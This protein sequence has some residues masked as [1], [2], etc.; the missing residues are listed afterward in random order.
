MN[1]IIIAFVIIATLF[2][3]CAKEYDDS[4]LWDKQD[5]QDKRLN[6]LENSIKDLKSEIEAAKKDIA[7]NKESITE[8]TTLVQ[9]FEDLSAKVDA[10]DETNKTA[11]KE[12]KE[13]LLETINERLNTLENDSSSSVNTEEIKALKELIKDLQ[14]TTNN[15]GHLFNEIYQKEFVTYC[16]SDSELHEWDTMEKVYNSLMNVSFVTN[17]DFTE[18]NTRLCSFTS[19]HYC[20]FTDSEGKSTSNIVI[21]EDNI[22]QF[23][24]ESNL[25]FYEIKKINEYSYFFKGVTTN[26]QYTQYL[27][28]LKEKKEEF[29]NGYSSYEKLHKVT[30]ITINPST[31]KMNLNESLPLSYSLT[32]STSNTKDIVWTSSDGTICTIEETENNNEI[33]VKAIK[34]GLCDI[35]ATS[36]NRI[37]G[38]CHIGV[39]RIKVSG[40]ELSKKDLD[41]ELNKTFKLN[42]IITPTVASIKD[43]I[44]TSN[45]SDIATVDETGLVTAINIGETVIKAT[46]KDGGFL[47]ECKINVLPIPLQEIS[48]I[49][50]SMDLFEDDIQN[51]ALIF[52][53]ENASNKN[54]VWTIEDETIAVILDNNKIKAL[55][56]GETILTAISEDG[57][58]K[59]SI[60]IKVNDF[61]SF[62]ETNITSSSVVTIMDRI[63]GGVFVSLTN[64]SSH[65]VKIIRL[66][67]QDTASGQNVL[68]ATFA[69]DEGLVKAHETSKGWGSNTLNSVYRPRFIYTVE[70]NGKQYTS[71]CLF[72]N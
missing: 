25:H 20:T 37:V 21:E 10:N 29:E 50:D 59:C 62:L 66:Q 17:Q 28:I 33:N 56:K 42:A 36:K 6:D 27:F 7:A 72:H 41:L 11:L 54:V 38:T 32:P 60:I 53:P 23:M 46:S 40:I 47:V 4:K 1:K 22:I 31:L 70:Y 57:S 19:K 69:E 16:P 49:S 52:T 30:A 18:M 48:Y 9:K 61:S 43:V 12:I 45:N 15:T 71:E 63:T 51:L 26:D 64:N 39:G 44:W 8:L 35:I 3:S 2:S 14:N 58:H 24:G 5:Q 65:D 68:Y 67:I 34:E 13:S 55:T